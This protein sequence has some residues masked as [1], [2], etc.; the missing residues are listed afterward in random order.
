MTDLPSVATG[1]EAYWDWSGTTPFR[2]RVGDHTLAQG[3]GADVA[4]VGVSEGPCATA[5]T[6]DGARDYLIIPA[7]S[8]G[9]L[10]LGAGG[11]AA[12][13]VFAWI[14]RDT[15]TGAI[16]AGCWQ[17]D[18]G[19]PRRQYAL[20]TGLDLYGGKDLV[21]GHVSRSGGP[22]P[23]YPYSRDY[24]A[25]VSPIQN[26]TWQFTAFTYDGTDV[27]A[28]LGPVFEP[29]PSYTDIA[30]ATYA[31][32]PYRFTAGLNTA[33]CDFTVGACKLTFGMWNFFRGRLGPLGIYSRALSLAE[34]TTLCRDFPARAIPRS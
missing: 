22:T 2:A 8:E 15:T 16:I 28:Y 31:K 33:P 11:Y 34:L 26:G 23:G 3:E 27:R 5:L 4:V 13:T 32:N 10:N 6:F 29:R 24:A 18:D 25:N 17:E 20:F 9:R 7:G 21:C 14:E 30:G 12:C 1:L 19:D